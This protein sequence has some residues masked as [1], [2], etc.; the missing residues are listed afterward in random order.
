MPVDTTTLLYPMSGF[1]V[2]IL[3]GTTGV[4]GGSLMTPL[5]ILLFGIHPGTAVGT[6]LLF[7]AATKFAGTAFHGLKG[8]V[9]WRITGR[10]ALGS[11]PATF[12][13]ID[14]LHAF[15]GSSSSYN[16][17][18]APILGVTLLLTAVSLLLRRP[19]LAFADRHWEPPRPAAVATL[20]V[21][22]GVVL[23]VLVSLTS[24]GA[25]AIGMAALVFL[26]PRAPAVQLVGS[27]I[28]HAVPLTLA[29]GIGH[30]YLGSVDWSLLG[31]LLMGSVPGI[32]LGS[33]IATRVPGGALRTILA[34]TLVV[35]ARQLLV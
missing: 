28:A 15:A 9:D 29:A 32:L 3:V 33:T 10:L 18:L 2:G 5:L 7:A 1:I 4:G 26:Y 17:L 24:V 22:A 19:I 20:T 27:D 8:T 30:W 16:R 21:V 31:L 23:G 6:D 34:L 14:V 13:T 35:A 25:G 11:I 12:V